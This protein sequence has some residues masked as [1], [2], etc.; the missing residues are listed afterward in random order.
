MSPTQRSLACC[1]R[2][3]WTAGIVERFNPHARVRHDLFGCLDL[4]VLDGQP[5]PLGVQACAGASHA[6]RRAKMVAEPR[7]RAWLASGARAE[8]W[9]WSKQGPRGKRKTWT[10]RREEIVSVDDVGAICRE[11]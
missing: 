4:I 9:S 5:G 1:R 3:G 7:L 8:I 2:H 10:L 11:P 6:A